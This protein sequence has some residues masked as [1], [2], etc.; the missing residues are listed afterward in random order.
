MSI[1]RLERNLIDR[2]QDLNEAMAEYDNADVDDFNMRRRKATFMA[3]TVAVIVHDENKKKKQDRSILSQLGQREALSFPDTALLLTKQKKT[4]DGGAQP[5]R[6]TSISAPKRVFSRGKCVSS[7]VDT[8][9]PPL[10]MI[11]KQETLKPPSVLPLE[12]LSFVPAPEMVRTAPVVTVS[13]WLD[14]DIGLGWKPFTRRKLIEYLR[15]K[16]G[17][18]H[19]DFVI[20]DKRFD[21]LMGWSVDEIWY[22]RTTNGLVLRTAAKVNE[23][24]SNLYLVN[25]RLLENE[26]APPIISERLALQDGGYASMRQ[27]AEELSFAIETYR[28]MET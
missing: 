21:Q 18:A 7:R 8:F 25:K 12:F 2:I 24:P 14:R 9:S 13:D 6:I 22:H 15:S 10:V 4:I 23:A 19:V 27:I 16:D 5:L 26:T 11:E 17:H 3:T 20:N 1:E 28:T